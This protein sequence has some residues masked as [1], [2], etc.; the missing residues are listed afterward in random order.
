MVVLDPA[1][2]TSPERRTVYPGF[3]D[4]DV[5]SHVRKAARGMSWTSSIVVCYSRLL[6]NKNR[7]EEVS[8]TWTLT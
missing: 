6:G 4:D 1:S 8:Y 7:A 5:S 3:D 2:H